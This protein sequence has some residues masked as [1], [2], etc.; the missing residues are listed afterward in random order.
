MMYLKLRRFY[1]Q[2]KSNEM[3]KVFIIHIKIFDLFDIEPCKNK[4]CP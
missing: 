4:M 1:A 2:K 3:H